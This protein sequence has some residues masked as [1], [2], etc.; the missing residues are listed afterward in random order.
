MSRD[1][2]AAANFSSSADISL[3]LNSA[4][5]RRNLYASSVITCAG[6]TLLFAFS[7][8]RFISNGYTEL[9]VM[10]GITGVFS[11]VSGAASAAQILIHNS[12][13]NRYRNAL[14]I[15]QNEGR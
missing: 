5:K 7:A 2:G 10:S 11:A 13:I 15:A 3:L 1:L 4:Q 9:A 12:D 6:G 14:R 8:V